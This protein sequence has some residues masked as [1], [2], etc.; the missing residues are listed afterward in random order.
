MLEECGIITRYRGKT[1]VKGAGYIR[2]Y[3]VPLDEQ[4]NLVYKENSAEF[5][6]KEDHHTPYYYNIR[7]SMFS[8]TSSEDDHMFVIKEKNNNKV[9]DARV[10]SDKKLVPKAPSIE[11][12]AKFEV[13]V[14]SIDD[15]IS[16]E[17]DDTEI[18]NTR[19]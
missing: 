4:F 13:R 2:T 16:S 9:Y 17:E 6:R 15:D 7:N 11:T 10:H 5:F 19:C 8:E 14:E 1:F 3:Y 12:G 18:D